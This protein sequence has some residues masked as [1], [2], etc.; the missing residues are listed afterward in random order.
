MRVVVQGSFKT[1]DL[2][3]KCPQAS[4]MMTTGLGNQRL[5]VGTVILL[6]EDR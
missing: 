1:M 5:T 6:N 2:G 3:W 4:E